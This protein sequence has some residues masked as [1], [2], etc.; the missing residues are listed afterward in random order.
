M[1]DIL[2]VATAGLKPDQLTDAHHLQYPRVDYL[3]LQQRIQTKILDYAVYESTLL[4]N[5][6]KYLDTQVRSDLYLALLTLFKEKKHDL[7]FAMSERVGIPLAGLHSVLPNPKPLVSMF[8]CWSQRQERV[9]TKLKLFSK[10]DSIIVHCQSMKCHFQELGASPEKIHV[11]P[12]SIDH[13]FFA[14]LKDVSPQLGLIMSLG[15]IRSRDYATLFRAIADLPV[16]LAVA[17]SGSWY[18]REKNTHLQSSIPQNVKLTGRLTQLELKK[19]YAQ[20]QFVVLPVYDSVFS[21]GA[22]ATLEAACMARPVIATR[23]RGLAD[24]IIDGETGILVE[25]GDVAGM[26]A[27]IQ[28]LLAHPEE[29]QRLGHNARQRIEEELNLDI[30]VERIAS[31]LQDCLT[32]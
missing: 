8:T 6:F 13:R 27:A 21:A 32:K 10:M 4:G 11:I 28:H 25:P 12:Y 18:A 30:Y 24:F 29:A 16:N 17:A 26:R 22:T 15:E 5:A 23:S 2:T 19:Y 3:E 7:V 20:S 31:L 9:I 14:P 1:T